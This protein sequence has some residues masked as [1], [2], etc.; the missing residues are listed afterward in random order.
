[1]AAIV[2][3]LFPSPIS[4]ARIAPPPPPF[5]P[6][7][8]LSRSKINWIPDFWWGRRCL[9]NLVS[10]VTADVVFRSRISCSLSINGGIFSWIV[11]ELEPPEEELSE[12][13]SGGTKVADRFERGFGSWKWLFF[14]FGNLDSAPLLVRCLW[15]IRIFSKKIRKN[16]AQLARGARFSG[17]VHTSMPK[18]GLEKPPRLRFSTFSEFPGVI[19][20][21]GLWI[22][23]FWAEM[24]FWGG[25]VAIL[26]WISTL[27][28]PIL[29]I[30]P[31]SSWS[32]PFSAEDLEKSI[33][34]KCFVEI[35]NFLEF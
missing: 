1:M 24:G 15:K 11:E 8:R 7:P 26:S 17:R 9:A 20:G 22:S 14:L 25:P 29:M 28:D 12:P 2:C 33:I 23:G 32:R 13:I 4:S 30:R 21:I 3:K 10:T 18:N 6:E 27:Q 16:R 35:L 5:F 31:S 34:F 19:G